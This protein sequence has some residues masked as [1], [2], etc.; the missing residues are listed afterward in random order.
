MVMV[1]R[2]D[3]VGRGTQNLT[4]QSP[5]AELK[6]EVEP[7]GADGGDVTLAK[8]CVLVPVLHDGACQPIGERHPRRTIDASKRL[9][10]AHK[11]SVPE[12]PEE[13]A[14]TGTDAA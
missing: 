3:A 14:A 7:M 13:V 8:G 5:E 9:G 12:L 1:K 10:T 6:D 11:A 2:P 4:L